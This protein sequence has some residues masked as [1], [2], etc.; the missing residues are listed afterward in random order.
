MFC[1]EVLQDQDQE[2]AGQFSKAIG[3]R[4]PLELQSGRV[5]R[6]VGGHATY[7]KSQAVERHQISS[8]L[9]KAP[10]FENKRR[11]SIIYSY[12]EC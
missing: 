10:I 2:C 4:T 3:I 9:S 12:F 7:Q 8:I 1:Y 5:Q 11:K 6:F